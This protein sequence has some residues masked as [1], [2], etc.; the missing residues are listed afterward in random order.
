[1]AAAR[2][3]AIVGAE[4]T[5]KS[6]LA[7]DLAAALAAEGHRVAQV[8]EHLREWCDARGRTPR[9]D[10]QAAILREQHRRIDAAAAAR[11]EFVVCDTTGLMTAVYS[12]HLFGDAALD[13]EAVAWHRR[14]DATLLTALDLPWEPDGH[15]RDGAHVRVPVDGLLRELLLAHRLPFA[16]VGGSGPRRLE[17]ALAALPRGWRNAQA[18]RAGLFTRLAEAAGGEADTAADTASAAG[19]WRCECCEPEAERLS[20]R[21]TP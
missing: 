1:V 5:G 19:G 20:R 13:A 18:P 3:I 16:V 17:A 10:E 8:E 9:A 15:Q 6:T 14:V 11:H 21:A 2:V 12:R 4:C 7:R